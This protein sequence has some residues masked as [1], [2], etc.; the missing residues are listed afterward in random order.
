VRVCLPKCVLQAL[1]RILTVGDAIE[2]AAI[3]TDILCRPWQPYSHSW[4][5]LGDDGAPLNRALGL[6]TL[7]HCLRTAQ[8]E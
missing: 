4:I 3:A 2:Q 8:C 6:S 1:Q 7:A 5:V